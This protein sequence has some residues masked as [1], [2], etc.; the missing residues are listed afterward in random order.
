MTVGT[1]A[2]NPIQRAILICNALLEVVQE[3]GANGAPAGVM[4][5][6]LMGTM[7]LNQ[8]MGCMNILEKA[9]KVRREHHC[10][11]AI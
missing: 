3:S 5:A 1:K 6:A 2:L 10:Y 4:Y 9:G 8:F 7:S 11:Y